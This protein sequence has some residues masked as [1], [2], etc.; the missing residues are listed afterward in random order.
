MNIN[1]LP[2]TILWMALSTAVIGLIAYR[3]WIARD[4]DDSLHVM[5]GEAGMV[6]RQEVLGRKLE[7]IDRGGKML[8]VIALAYGLLVGAVYLY[9]N[10]AAVST[11]VWK[12]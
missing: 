12:Y 9:Q 2:F 3:A 5:D 7:A 4:E 8:T 6:L 1:L 10:W 11:D